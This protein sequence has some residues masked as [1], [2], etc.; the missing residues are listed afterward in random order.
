MQEVKNKIDELFKEYETKDYSLYDLQ[1][2]LI[3]YL[4]KKVEKNKMLSIED[5]KLIEILF[6]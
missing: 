6:K 5:I 2:L 4:Y 3:N 1:K